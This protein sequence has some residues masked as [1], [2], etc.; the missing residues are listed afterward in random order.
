MKENAV[1]TRPTHRR[2][3][4]GQQVNFEGLRRMK[5]MGMHSAKIGTAGSNTRAFGLYTSCGFKLI[6][7]ERTYL[8]ALDR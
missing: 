5:A 4:L 6:D 8:K 7:R 2:R 1:G 3:G